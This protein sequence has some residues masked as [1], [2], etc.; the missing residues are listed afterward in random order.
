MDTYNEDKDDD[1]PVPDDLNPFKFIPELNR[2][3]VPLGNPKTAKTL[4]INESTT[5]RE[6]TLHDE[7]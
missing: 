2:S 1:I 3:K 7:R 6:P 5:P 4:R